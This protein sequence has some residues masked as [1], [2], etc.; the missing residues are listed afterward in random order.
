MYF[1][2]KKT[3]VYIVYK[4]DNKLITI[5][6]HEIRHLDGESDE[7]VQAAIVRFK[8][9]YD[10]KTK[11][12]D[13]ITCHSELEA[14]IEEYV[15]WKLQ[16]GLDPLTAR[17]QKTLLIKGGSYMGWPLSAWQE[18]A[19]GFED[20]ARSTLSSWTS[21]R[22]KIYL[23]AFWKWCVEGGLVAGELYVRAPKNK[24][25]VFT[26]LKRTYTPNEVHDWKFS[27]PA[28]ELIALLGYFFSLRP[29]EMLAL[30]VDDFSAGSAAEDLE[31]CKVMKEYG[32]YSKF[33]VR[34]EKQKDTLSKNKNPKSESFGWVACFD[35]KAAKRIVALLKTYDPEKPIFPYTVGH[36]IKQ[37]RS[38]ELGKMKDVRRASIY[39]LGHHTKFQPIPLKNHARHKKLD[40]TL[41]YCRRPEADVRRGLDLG[42]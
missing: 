27:D 11:R 3:K 30:R 38:F 4:K 36:Y 20:W 42:A 9:L 24:K 15:Q 5:P 25:P 23:R 22:C 41:L 21:N 29:Q 10:V 33:A 26:P 37:W 6:R 17:Q 14:K 34:V 16:N 32:L 19:L 39:W 31:C 12:P 35:E 40:T 28:L 13:L 18:R 2:R 1:F 7:V 8:A